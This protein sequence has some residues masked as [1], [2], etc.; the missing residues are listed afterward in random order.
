MKAKQAIPVVTCCVL[1]DFSENGY[2]PISLYVSQRLTKLQGDVIVESGS[3]CGMAVNTG[4]SA[5]GVEFR[6]SQRR[7]ACFC[8]V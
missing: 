2:L 7:T 3:R 8:K 1:L 6:L 4:A 5:Q